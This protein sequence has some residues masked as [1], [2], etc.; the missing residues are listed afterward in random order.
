MSWPHDSHTPYSPLSIRSRACS[1][2]WSRSMAFCCIDSS[3]SYSNFIEPA[4]ALPGSGLRSADASVWR[5]CSRAWAAS[6][7]ISVRRSRS[8]SSRV[9]YFSSVDWASL[10][11]IKPP[12]GS[13]DDSKRPRT[14]DHS[15]TPVDGNFACEC[16]TAISVPFEGDSIRLPEG[17]CP[18]RFPRPR[19]GGARPVGSHRRLHPQRLRETARQG[20]RLLRR[21]SV[22][23]RQPALRPSPRLRGEGRRPPV[24]DDARVPGGAAVGLGHPR[25]PGGDG[26][27]EA[28]RP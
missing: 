12:F 15:Q 2:L 8:S 28:A 3:F 22:R 4:S 21:A 27:T 6:S 25:A 26:S 13:E 16:P 5:A 14:P 19:V 7:I 18:G 24:L 10:R 17:L 23:Q 9:R 20:V 11:A 1:T